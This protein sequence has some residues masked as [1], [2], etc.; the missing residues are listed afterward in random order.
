MSHSFP[1]IRAGVLMPF[2]RW[3]QE[4][5]RPVEPRLRAVDLAGFPWDSPDRAVPLASV[6]AFGRDLQ[7]REGPDIGCRVVVS[8]HSLMQL[9]TLGQMMLSMATPRDAIGFCCVAMSRHCTHERTAMVQMPGCV[10]ITDEI[11][12]RMDPETRHL[13][14]QYVAALMKVVFDSVGHCGE[15]L[16][17]AELTPHPE[18]GLDHLTRWL[19]PNLKATGTRRLRLVVSDTVMDR[20]I[21]PQLQYREPV[22]PPDIWTTIRGDGSFSATAKVVIEGMLDDGL[23]TVERLAAASGGSLRTLQR[24]LAEEG[25]SFAG[26]LDEVRRERALRNLSEGTL[27][28]SEI[29]AQLGYSGASSFTRAVRRW[30]EEPPRR[31]YRKPSDRPT[32]PAISG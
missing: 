10:V 5:G 12:V 9:A 31:L 21:A 18:H 14:H 23:P 16:Q 1:L 27:A 30:T 2:L 6:L 17:R 22:V 29:G 20:P 13:V 28:I 32:K 3:M 19:G 7:R 8:T 24:R 15:S 4:N 26:I 11:S 25:R